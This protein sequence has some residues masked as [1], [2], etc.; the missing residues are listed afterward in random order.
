MSKKA[1]NL[2]RISIYISGYRKPLFRLLKCEVCI[3]CSRSVHIVNESGGGFARHCQTEIDP[4]IQSRGGVGRCYL[5]AV[6]HIEHGFLHAGNHRLVD[7]ASNSSSWDRKFES[8]LGHITF[9]EI[10][11]EI[12]FTVIL[13]KSV[14]RSLSPFR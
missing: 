12:S 6:R 11:R 1:E 13:M 14:L 2:P 5:H 4:N 3:R 8:Q 10:D 7:S 9:M